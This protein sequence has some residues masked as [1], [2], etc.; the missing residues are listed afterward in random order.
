MICAIPIL[1]IGF[2]LY[3][4][5]SYTKVKLISFPINVLLLEIINLKPLFSLLFFGT[6][7][8]LEKRAYFSC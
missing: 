4:I 2:V 5:L 3:R 1:P 8:K 6:L 7:D